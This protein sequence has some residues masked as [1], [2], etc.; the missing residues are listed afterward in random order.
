[1][2]LSAPPSH[3][4]EQLQEGISMTFFDRTAFPAGNRG[5]SGD[6]TSLSSG[7]FIHDDTWKS[8]SAVVALICLFYAL[9]N[10]ALKW[11]HSPVSSLQ[12]MPLSSLIR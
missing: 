9:S 5:F 11:R 8:E 12:Y 6:A 7:W 1:M 3:L 4:L 2:C 10:A